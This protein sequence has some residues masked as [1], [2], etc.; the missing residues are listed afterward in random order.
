MVEENEPAEVREKMHRK[1]YTI[2]VMLHLISKGNKLFR[3]G[4]NGQQCQMLPKVHL[5]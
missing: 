5:R 2:N 4:G 1:K 3:D